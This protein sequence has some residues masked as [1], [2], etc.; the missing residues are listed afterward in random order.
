[1][2]ERKVVSLKSSQPTLGNDTF[3]FVE[4]D[5]DSTVNTASLAC[6]RM[7]LIAEGYHH[8]AN[9]IAEHALK[10]KSSLDSLVY[11][12]AFNFRH[13]FE[14]QLKRALEFLNRLNPGST[15]IELVHTLL[16]LWN[17]LKPHVVSRFPEQNRPIDFAT[18][19]SVLSDYDAVD[20]WSFA[21][22]YENDR[23]GNQN[24]ADVTHVNIPN[25]RDRS[26]QLY[27]QL[28]YIAGTFEGD[29]DAIS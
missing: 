20:R 26:N 25:L 11:P 21:F 3:C 16:P 23:K 6:W 4:G 10:E 2:N 12:I 8:A 19:E 15:A 28:N 7:D 18:I 22:R 13:A 1:M 29:V 27:S 9:V 5:E 17:S 14:L 24:L